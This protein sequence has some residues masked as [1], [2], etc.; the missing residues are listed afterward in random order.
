MR[1]QR[2]EKDYWN[3]YED[4]S[5]DSSFEGSDG[6]ESSPDQLSSDG[7]EEEVIKDYSKRGKN[8]HEGLG[9]DERRVQLGIEERIFKPK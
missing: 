3:E 8:I 7:R 9:D 1:R 5:L 4:F 6:N 2:E